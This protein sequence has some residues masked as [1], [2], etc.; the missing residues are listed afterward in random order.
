MTSFPMY[1]IFWRGL[2]KFFLIRRWLYW[3]PLIF[4]YFWEVFPFFW[5]GKEKMVS[6]WWGGRNVSILTFGLF[7]LGG[8]SQPTSSMGGRGGVA[9]KFGVSSNSLKIKNNKHFFG[10]VSLL[11]V[12]ST[13]NNR[14]K[15]LTGKMQY[16][17][18]VSIC[19]GCI[20]KPFWLTF[21]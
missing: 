9:I 12:T 8:K 19:Q 7:L 4:G 3:H 11:H 5:R 1:E 15:I 13:S 16:Y 20:H 14:P 10:S 2:W 6:F 21:A 18:S 17:H